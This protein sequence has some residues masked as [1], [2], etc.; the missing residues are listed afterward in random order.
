MIHEVLE[1]LAVFASSMFKFILGPILGKGFGL[2]FWETALLTAGGMMASVFLFSSILGRRIHCW[3][4]RTFF[5]EKKL[6][7]KRSRK[8]VR[9]WRTYGLKGVAFLTPVLFTPIGGTIVASSFGEH[10]RKIFKYM[11]LSAIFWGFIFSFVIVSLK[12]EN[13]FVALK[14]H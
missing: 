7:S 6:F 14:I 8:T 10:K 1:Y 13:L 3:I 9:I 5:K 11:L 4:M 12:V 2:T